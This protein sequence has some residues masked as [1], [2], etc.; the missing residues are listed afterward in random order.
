MPGTVR[1]LPLRAPKSRYWQVF[2]LCFL[3]AAVM[4]L[5]HVVIDA[6]AGG[7]FFHYAGDFNEQMI[8][9]NAYANYFL[10]SGGGSFSWAADLGSGFVN[11]FSYYCLGTPFFWLSLLLPARLV[12]WAIVPLLCLKFAV[13]GGGAYL[14][15][16]RWLRDVAGREDWAVLAGCLYAFCGFN[17]YNIF[18][19][20]FLDVAALFPYL[21]K[22]LDD[23]VLDGRYGAFPFWVALNMLNNYFFFVGQVVFLILYFACMLAGRRFRLTVPL[24]ARL[25]FEALLGCAMGCLLF[26]PAGLSLLQN[27]RTIDPFNGRGFLQYGN[28]QQYGAIFY[29]AF[30]MPD[31]AYFADLFDGGVFKWTSLSAWLPVVGVAGGI[32]FCRASRGHPFAR[33][34]RVCV[35]CAL[36]PV[37]NSMFYA[38]NSSFYARWYYM[39]VLILCAAT[40]RVL[41]KEPDFRTELPGALRF[42][43]LATASAALFA[44]VPNEKDGVTTLGVVDYQ[45]RFW[46]IF[47]VSMLSVAL[48]ALLLRLR[49]RLGRRFAGALLAAVLGFSA[50]YGTLHLSFG[51]YGQWTNDAAYVRQTWGEAQELNAALPD[52]AEAGFYRIDAYNAYNNLG[53]WLDKS[54]LQHFNST[55]APHILE[56]YP[57]VGVT[58]DV[59]SKPDTDLYALRGL[60]SVRY[61]LVPLDK[62]QAWQEE[63]LG[64]W[65][66]CG[67]TASYALYEN[68]N[69]LPMG[70]A[71][72]CYVT[73]DQL[74][75]IPKNQRGNVLLK[76]IVLPRPAAEAVPAPAAAPAPAGSGSDA[77]PELTPTPA[78][79]RV[80]A[81]LDP[82]YNELLTPLPE[83]ELRSRT[84]DDYCRDIIAR[85]A[86][87]VTAFTATRTG[88]TAV[89]DYDRDRMVLFTVPYD[90]GFS[91]TVNGAAVPIYKVDNGLMAVRVPAGH[92]EIVFTYHTPGLALSAA[93]SA[94]ALALYLLYRAHLRRQSRRPPR[95]TV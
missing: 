5:P 20:F 90:D 59:S 34:L 69:Y 24:F 17:V 50:L 38:L 73:A 91:A 49:P 60:L 7:G 82:V 62:E 63:K 47:A 4:F 65:T 83:Q 52:E 8:P 15:S 79:Q 89:A 25:A 43:A 55:V 42:T 6:V 75:A 11:T 18:F 23:A 33:L 68:E 1:L 74:A 66:R 46:G 3:T 93:V 2:G 41:Q 51:K 80:A 87:G 26:F 44:L 61:T 67:Q 10:K 58:R 95:R 31:A 84:Y 64:G 21:L 40:A 57:S 13:A 16:R 70:F 56:F 85:R 27:P 71:L 22:S 28:A 14:W 37:L 86:D 81:A 72:D 30:L 36:V 94:A 45:P 53:I 32:A 35:V 88:F 54:C 77:A 92:A 78:P 48:F 76:A 19:Y 12:P 9:F 39:P 29:S